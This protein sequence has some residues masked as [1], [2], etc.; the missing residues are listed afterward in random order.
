MM[1]TYLCICSKISKKIHKYIHTQGLPQTL[2]YLSLINS[3][4]HLIFE[5][6]L[7]NSYFLPLFYTEI[8]TGKVVLRSVKI[9]KSTFLGKIS[10]QNVIFSNEM[11]KKPRYYAYFSIEFGKDFC[12]IDFIL[13]HMQNFLRCVAIQM[14]RSFSRKSGHT[15]KRSLNLGL[16]EGK[17]AQDGHAAFES[18]SAVCDLIVPS[19]VT[20]EAFQANWTKVQQLG[21]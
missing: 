2:L 11:E 8:L 1:H 7:R 15:D 4:E 6:V 14:I 18:L 17:V 16:M 9:H 5:S 10:V 20:R 19:E 12:S 21:R 3:S 13:R